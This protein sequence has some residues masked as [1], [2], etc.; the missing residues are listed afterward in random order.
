MSER[1]RVYSLLLIMAIVTTVV[2]VISISMLYNTAIDEEGA[3]L[4]G[5]AQIQARLIEAIARHEIS[6]NYTH[7]EVI[8]FTVDQIREAY[9]IH[10]NHGETEEF[11]L[12][13]RE[14]DL[15]IFL[16]SHRHRDLKFPE[17]VQF[18]FDL[19][20]PQRL[21]ISGESGVVIGLDYRGKMVLAAYEP[22]AILDMGIVV[23]IDLAEIR[24]PFYS[25]IIYSGL[26]LIFFVALGSIVFLRI[27]NPILQNLEGSLTALAES[28]GRFRSLFDKA[29]LSYQSL[30]I[31]GNIIEV[32]QTWLDTLGYEREEVIGKWFGE[33]HTPQSAESVKKTFP[34]FKAEG[35]LDNVVFELIKK[36]GDIIIAEFT[37]KISY[38][39][40]GNFTQTHCI[41]VDITKR[42]HQENEIRQ[43]NEELEQ[44]VKDRTAELTATNEELEAFSYSISHDLRAPLR[45]ISGFSAILKEEYSEA[46]DDEG[47]RKLDILREST[48]KMDRLITDLLSLSRLGR[49]DIRI[50]P[51]NISSTAR[52]VFKDLTKGEN[53][54]KFDFQI[55]DYPNVEADNNLLEILLTNLLSNAIKFTRGQDPAIIKFGYFSDDG[56][57]TYFVRDNGVGF[58]MDYVDKLFSPF[59][60]LHTEIDFEGTGIGL[61]IVRRIAQR[62]GG[63]VWVESEL[64]K[65]TT[66]YFTL[67][68]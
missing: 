41:F 61:A 58:D 47:N 13:K 53:D 65:G 12:A 3:R 49:Q 24:A 27:S 31:D 43:L 16:F 21:A 18:N 20:E 51:T 33:F 55:A 45:A 10:E 37:G 48:L 11:T 50:Q 9:E 25:A 62:H 34:N 56:P 60:R 54:R 52:K 7:Q 19:D 44:R 4:T 26:A 1:R 2:A 46:L 30:N 66:F 32:N 35:R 29:P 59:Q 8:G 5:S 38:D 57:S 64:D 42:V 36:G 14:E 22:V 63:R 28:E 39:A 15:I 67:S 23:K 68:G 6:E 17:S 40:Q